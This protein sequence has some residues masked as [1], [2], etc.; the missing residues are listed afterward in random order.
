MNDTVRPNYNAGIVASGR[1]SPGARDGRGLVGRKVGH[2][3]GI[4][5]LELGG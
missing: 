1:R 3:L 2:L 4:E 5:I